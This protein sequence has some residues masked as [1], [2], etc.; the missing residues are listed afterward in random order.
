MS[1]D[2]L[3]A[4]ASRAVGS[5]S[6]ASGSTEAGFNRYGL[7][8]TSA[9]DGDDQANDDEDPQQQQARGVQVRLSEASVEPAVW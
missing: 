6:R 2:Q 4:A 1:A 3:A 8:H 7:T 5:S 9:A